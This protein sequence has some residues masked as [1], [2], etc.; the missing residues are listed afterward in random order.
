ML[1][2]LKT[3]PLEAMTEEERSEWIKKIAARGSQACSEASAYWKQMDAH[4]K[5]ITVLMD[6]FKREKEEDERLNIMHVLVQVLET[7]TALRTRHF[8]LRDEDVTTV[9]DWEHKILST[10]EGKRAAAE[11]DSEK[12][13]FLQKYFQNKARLGLTT[14]QDV[15][16][17]TG[18]DRR[19]IS[20][21]ESAAVKPQFK[22]IER[23]AEKF[24][25]PVEDF[26]LP[27]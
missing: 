17:L 7:M 6:E 27:K 13:F 16:D 20:R 24:G 9:E 10:E 8:D 1:S 14:Q 11:I 25:V 15:A 21:I 4:Y 3:V 2:V 5:N 12:A 18:I 26:L 22:T 23:L 19:Q